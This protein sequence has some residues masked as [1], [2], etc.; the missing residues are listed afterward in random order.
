MSGTFASDES[1]HDEN[2][3]HLRMFMFISFI[4]ERM[5]ERL[6]W[7]KENRVPLDLD[8]LLF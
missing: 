3:D 8:L 1:S 4:S 5:K 6:E 7:G 2:Y